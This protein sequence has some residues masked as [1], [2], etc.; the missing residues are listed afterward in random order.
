VRYEKVY[1]LQE[2]EKYLAKKYPEYLWYDQRRGRV[3]QSV[4]LGRIAFVLDPIACLNQMKDMGEHG[5]GL[6]GASLRLARMFVNEAGLNWSNIGITGSQLAGLS[7]ESSDIDLVV[8]G[9]LYARRLFN[10]LRSRGNLRGVKRYS[11]KKLNEHVELR[12]GAENEWRQLLRNIEG[13]KVLQGEFESYDFFVRNVKLPEERLYSYEDLSFV[14]EGIRTVRAKVVDDQDAIFTPCVYR[15]ECAKDPRLKLI[16][17]YRGRF[18]E[19]AKQG[20]LVE[21]RGRAE[22][23]RIEKTGEE[24]TQL[25]LGEQADDYMIPRE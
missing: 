21:V 12:W 25:V 5:D 17:S 4:Q 7:I 3:V 9:S 11:G 6:Q 1:S 22:R 14:S 8:Y 2:R 20:M 10:L 16:M 13:K 18:T 24:F 15:V 23:V 19:Q